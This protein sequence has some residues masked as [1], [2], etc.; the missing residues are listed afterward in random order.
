MRM[1]ISSKDDFLSRAEPVRIYLGRVC[2]CMP[3]VVVF[4]CVPRLSPGLHR[5]HAAS[6]VS[7]PSES[8]RVSIRVMKPPV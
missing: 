2:E 7:C 8:V 5:V 1:H 4:A 3:I 6:S